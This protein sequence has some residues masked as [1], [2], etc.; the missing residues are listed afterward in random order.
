MQLNAIFGKQG[1][2]TSVKGV[3]HCSIALTFVFVA[4]LQFV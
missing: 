4:L 2:M 1:P 3:I